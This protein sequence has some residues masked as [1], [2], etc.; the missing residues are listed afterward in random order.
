MPRRRRSPSRAV[1]TGPVPRRRP[2]P[3]EGS[4][5]AGLPTPWEGARWCRGRVPAGSRARSPPGRMPWIRPAGRRPRSR[6][7]GLPRPGTVGMSPRSVRYRGGALDRSRPVSGSPTPWTARLGFR[8]RPARHGSCD[9]PGWVLAGHPES[10]GLDVAVGSRGPV[11]ARIGG[12]SRGVQIT[13]PAIAFGYDPADAADPV[14]GNQSRKEGRPCTVGPGEL[15]GQPRIPALRD[16]QLVPQGQDLDILGRRIPRREPGPS[17]QAT[18]REIHQLQRHS[19]HHRS[20]LTLSAPSGLCCPSRSDP[21]DLRVYEVLKSLQPGQDVPLRQSRIATGNTVPQVEE[22]RPDRW[23]VFHNLLWNLL[24]SQLM[25]PAS[26]R[27]A[28]L[29]AQRRRGVC[30]K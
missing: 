13:M 4:G 30:R 6:R 18:H 20:S 21:G 28:R 10:Q 15:A 9:I 12:P 16:G 26:R 1:E 3:S 8:G 2:G 27:R 25:L 11:A 5:P 14:P 23:P 22:N 17:E 29:P 19:L 24:R 7:R